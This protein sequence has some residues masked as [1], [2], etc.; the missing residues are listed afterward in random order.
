M[1]LACVFQ[2]FTYF[3]IPVLFFL[4]DRIF[5]YKE[6]HLTLLWKNHSATLRMSTPL[7]IVENP[8]VHY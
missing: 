5:A 1:T 6:K 7:L 8:E 4:F 2:V 3:H